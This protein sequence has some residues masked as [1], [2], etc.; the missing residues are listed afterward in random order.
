MNRWIVG[1]AASTALLLCA[2]REVRAQAAT[3]WPRVG[4]RLVRVEEGPMSQTT[5]PARNGKGDVTVSTPEACARRMRDARTGRE[6][7]LR[8][9]TMKQ[10]FAQHD[11]G[12]TTIATSRLLAAE[13]E[14]SRIELQGDTLSTRVVPVDCMTSRVVA[15]HTGT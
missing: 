14:Y 15:R 12:D 7:L 11:A 10:K 4:A 13:G 8:H 3:S 9:S 1:V 5:L 6:Y 2:A